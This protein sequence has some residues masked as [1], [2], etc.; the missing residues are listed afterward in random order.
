MKTKRKER[1]KPY[2]VNVTDD[3]IR[4][5]LSGD[6]Q[7][8]AVAL[9]L[10]RATGD[11]DAGVY[12]DSLN[13]GGFLVVHG[14]EIRSPREVCDFIYAFDGLP[15]KDKRPII[16][17]PLPEELKPFRFVLPSL[18]NSKWQER[19]YECEELYSPKRLDDEG[20]CPECRAATNA[21]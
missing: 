17:D 1:A 21:D 3:D 11:E 2:R 14:R 5:G 6:C 18:S 12:E 19:C 13:G 7:R 8:C 15:R 20:Y 4:N 9:A 10:R 16:P